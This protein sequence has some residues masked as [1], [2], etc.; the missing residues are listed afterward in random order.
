MANIKFKIKLISILLV[1]FLLGFWA[2]AVR[3]EI[4]AMLYDNKLLP[5]NEKLTEL[6][7]EDYLNLPT[8]IV[9]AEKVNFSFAIHN[10]EGEAREYP[11]TVFVKSLDNRLIVIEQKSV[12]L[13]DGETKIVTVSYEPT[14]TIPGGTVNVDLNRM[15]QQIHFLIADK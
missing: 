3:A 14:E 2:F 6:Y 4:Y 11:Y 5:I 1:A 10:L 13:S 15:N 9:A 12:T 7:F 8:K